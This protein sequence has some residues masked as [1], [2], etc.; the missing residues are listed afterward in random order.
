[1][2]SQVILLR[3]DDERRADE[4]IGAFA[5]QTGLEARQTDGGASFA[6]DGAAHA[7]NVIQTLDEIDPDWTEHVALGD[8]ESI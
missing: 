5:E 2:A 3:E 6:I 8:P 1:M 4:I 7:I